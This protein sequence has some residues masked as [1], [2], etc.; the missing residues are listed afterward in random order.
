MSYIRLAIAAGALALSAAGGAWVGYEWRDGIAAKADLERERAAAAQ[1]AA[2]Q[3]GMD[4]ASAE[5]ERRLALA[6]RTLAA[7]RGDADRVRDLAGRVAASAE[8]S[9]R[10]RERIRVLSGLVAESARLLEEG[11]G[12]A[13]RLDA[14][15]AGCAMTP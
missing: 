5:T 13:G 3:K 6:A 9:E 15:H 10:D 4:L 14:R 7:T 11:E 12:V 8:A 2:I 1:V